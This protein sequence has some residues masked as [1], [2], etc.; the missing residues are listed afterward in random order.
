MGITKKSL[1][2]RQHLKKPFEKMI[3]NL[4]LIICLPLSINAMQQELFKR[5][6][7]PLTSTTNQTIQKA[8][9]K[10]ECASKCFYMAT[11]CSVFFFDLKKKGCIITRLEHLPSAN[12]SLENQKGILGYV[13]MGKFPFYTHSGCQLMGSRIMGSIV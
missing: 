5:M 12:N 10:L 8:E 3:L 11:N 7:F 4:I 1:K 9:T 2:Q 13:S 6:V